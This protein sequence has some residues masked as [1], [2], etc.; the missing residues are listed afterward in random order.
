MPHRI[1]TIEQIAHPQSLI[2]CRARAAHRISGG[3]GNHRP[4]AAPDS[5]RA[6]RSKTPRNPCIS[7][8]RAFY[9][10]SGNQSQSPREAKTPRSWQCSNQPPRATPI[11]ARR[12]T[13]CSQTVIEEAA[14]RGFVSG[15]AA[16]VN[17]AGVGGNAVP[18]PPSLSMSI[19]EPLVAQG[20]AQGQGQGQK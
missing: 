15:T 9:N 6:K 14:A 8:N 10:G 2:L 19:S 12:W 4:R 13:R 1:S 11:Q 5:G 20:R 7:Q 18:P 3:V 17:G 16:N